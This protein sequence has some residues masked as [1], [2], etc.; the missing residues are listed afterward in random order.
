MFDNIASPSER[1]YEEKKNLTFSNFFCQISVI[2]R[3][4]MKQLRD[5]DILYKNASV[6]YLNKKFF[7]PKK[8]L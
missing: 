2:L 4:K 7:S 3:N 6:T 5:Y 8:Q 1:Y